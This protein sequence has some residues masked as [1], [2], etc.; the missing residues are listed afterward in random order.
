MPTAS[1]SDAPAITYPSSSTLSVTTATKS[2]SAMLTI[3]RRLFKLFLLL[4]PINA[5]IEPNIPTDGFRV[6]PPFSA[7]VASVRS[8]STKEKVSKCNGL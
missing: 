3:T 2:A 8:D 7:F 6:S 1:S 5:R 4:S